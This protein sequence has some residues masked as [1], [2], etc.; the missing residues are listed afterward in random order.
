[1]FKG[2][3]HNQ[4]IAMYQ[5]YGS[6]EWFSKEGM[7]EIRRL[8][9]NGTFQ[10]ADHTSI[11]ATIFIFGSRFVKLLKNASIGTRYKSRLVVQSYGDE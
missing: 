6:T 1:M 10:I 11:R 3:G 7:E 4:L 9:E 8:V 2:E 5:R